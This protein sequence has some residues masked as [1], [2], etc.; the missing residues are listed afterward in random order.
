MQI[1]AMGIAEASNRSPFTMGIEPLSKLLAGAGR[2]WVGV[3][4]RSRPRAEISFDL[5]RLANTVPADHRIT[6]P[7]VPS[8]ASWAS[9]FA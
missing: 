2:L 1:T 9:L 4:Q 8:I 6:T 5:K 7:S 3:F